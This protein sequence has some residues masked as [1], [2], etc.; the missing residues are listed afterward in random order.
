MYPITSQHTVLSWRPDSILP[1]CH[2]LVSMDHWQVSLSSHLTY[3]C[4]A[5][6]YV[7]V[8]YRCMSV[9]MVSLQ[10]YWLT[11]TE[12]DCRWHWRHGWHCHRHRLHRHRHRCHWRRHRLHR[13]RHR[14]HWRRNADPGKIGKDTDYQGHEAHLAPQCWFNAG[15]SSATL[16]QHWSRIGSTSRVCWG[17]S[18]DGLILGQCRRRWAN[19]KPE[20]TRYLMFP[21]FPHPLSL[22]VTT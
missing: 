4:H 10:N 17:D 16:A 18:N 8:M 20:L 15:P 5:A 19:I 13:H 21:P 12:D 1:A 9:R 3:G 2:A 6:Y 14:C 11:T 22:H 7:V